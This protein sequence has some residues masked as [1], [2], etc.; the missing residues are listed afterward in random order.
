MEKFQIQQIGAALAFG[1]AWITGTANQNPTTDDD[2][3]CWIVDATSG[4]TYHVP[5]A[6]A[7]HWSRYLPADPREQ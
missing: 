7:P 6:A 3:A 5:V 2:G 4:D 1:E